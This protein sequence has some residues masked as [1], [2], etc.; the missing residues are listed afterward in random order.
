MASSEIMQLKPKIYLKGIDPIEILENF[1][2][3]KY[4]DYQLPEYKLIIDQSL[5]IVDTRKIGNNAQESGIYS[6]QNRS[7]M[8]TVIITTNHDKF[9]LKKKN[10]PQDG[11]KF[12]C[13]WCLGEI[14]PEKSIGIPIK[15]EYDKN[16]GMST[17]HIDDEYC[18]FSCMY[19][20]YMRGPQ[21]TGGKYATH[22][23]TEQYIH[24][25]FS[26]MHPGKELK[27]AKPLRL[28]NIF[29]GGLLTDA[30]YYDGSLHYQQL[31]NVVLLPAKVEYLERKN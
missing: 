14:D 4:K 29:S 18:N 5:N 9:Q 12:A 13:L 25:M 28:R 31:P 11:K 24:T 7:N 19:S 1:F 30:Q 2:N 15:F 3:G 20:G 27:E 17:F 6:Y 8:K 26:L 16:T 22:L 10:L 23:D 21:T